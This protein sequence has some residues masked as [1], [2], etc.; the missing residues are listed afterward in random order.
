MKAGN[1]TR[2]IALDPLFVQL[3]HLDCIPYRKI[4]REVFKLANA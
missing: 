1:P 2:K 4:V 3:G